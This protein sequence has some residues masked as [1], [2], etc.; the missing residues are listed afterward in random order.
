MTLKL[1]PRMVPSPLWGV[2]LRT[3]LGSRW[4]PEVSRPIRE[5]Q[6]LC[7]ICGGYGADS[8]TGWRTCC[9]EDWDYSDADPIIEEVLR[10]LGDTFDVA[11]VTALVT[12]V[13]VLNIASRLG[14]APF[15][16]RLVDLQCVCWRCN[17]V[18][19]Y[20]HTETLNKGSDWLATRAARAHAARVNKVSDER[21]A[22]IIYGAKVIW[23]IRS[24]LPWSIEWTGW[25][26]IRNV[27]A[28]RGRRRADPGALPAASFQFGAE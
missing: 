25:E 23:A 10:I 28:G 11:G 9:D 7:E 3:D 2:A 6:S 24:C 4:L 12:P 20:G 19:H 26:R 15:V 18:I 17:Q 16:A 5:Y 8:P 1:T 13:N 21:V 22:K 27:K 14:S